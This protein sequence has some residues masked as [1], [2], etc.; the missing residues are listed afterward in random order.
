MK[1]VKAIDFAPL[2]ETMDNRESVVVGKQNFL[3]ATNFSTLEEALSSDDEKIANAASVITK[4]E[5]DAQVIY[6]TNAAFYAQFSALVETAASL[7]ARV[8]A[9]EA[10]TK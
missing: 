10:K 6:N 4:I 3:E 1:K 7:T 5:A 2:L 8:E 9:L